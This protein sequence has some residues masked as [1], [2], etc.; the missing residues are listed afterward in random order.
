MSEKELHRL[1]ELQEV[2]LNLE[3]ALD[4]ESGLRAENDALL[5]VL[6][7]IARAPSRDVLLVS[8]FTRLQ[9]ALSYE[10]AA[11]ISLEPDGVR[12]VLFATND[13]LAQTMLEQ[14]RLLER[15]SG[16]KPIHIF[17]AAKLEG[18]SEGARLQGSLL[19]SSLMRSK[20]KIVAVLG[21][22]ENSHFQKLHM[23]IMQSIGLVSDQLL[24]GMELA[25][26]AHENELKYRMLVEYA[27][28]GIGIVRDCHFKYLNP[29]LIELL[30]VPRQELSRMRFDAFVDPMDLERFTRQRELLLQDRASASSV[31]IRLLNGHKQ[32]LHVEFNIARI[33]YEKKPAELI[34]VRDITGRKLMQ[35]Q[36]SQTRKLEAIG[37]L[38][39]GVAHEINTP[40]QYIG[41]NLHFLQL[42]SKQL[43]HVL[44]MARELATQE[45]DRPELRQQLAQAIE[46]LEFEE[47]Q[48]QYEA[49]IA[50]SLGGVK[51]VSEIVSAMRQFSHPGGKERSLV[52]L[53]KV[54][55]EALTVTRN[56]WKYDAE[57]RLE[58]APD[59]P[60][61]MCHAGE[62]SQVL[63]N[64]IINAS[65]AIK[66]KRQATPG[67]EMGLLELRTSLVGGCIEL[68]LKDSGTGIPE[69][70][71]G[72]IFDPFFTTK[73]IGEGTGQGLSIVY[74]SIVNH[75]GGR[76]ELVTEPGVGTEFILY[77]PLEQ[78]EEE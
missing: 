38:A 13:E 20:R 15:A 77:L 67:T 59:L 17:D 31:E 30:G 63:L 5:G 36:L 39:A 66:S 32:Q 45:G 76:I 44:Q 55:K 8:L 29:R 42:E 73:E 3:R 40:V 28:D 6:G 41:D 16:G 9:A 56:Y 37:Q 35:E 47:L 18:K 48:E 75:M 68:R 11:A 22:P 43:L 78:E 58:L 61:L 21:H 52:D 60:L 49:A 26:R 53:N 74:N 19:L 24:Q 50:D 7:S 51:R 71:Q 64:L 27:S 4:R 70:Y 62:L 23:R 46:D 14:T 69:Q 54:L 57:S 2:V 33:V 65:D 72:R 10:T 12:R 25:N 34:I 1:E